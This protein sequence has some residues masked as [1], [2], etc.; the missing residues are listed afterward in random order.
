MV[1]PKFIPMKKN[2]FLFALAIMSS[3]LTGIHAQNSCLPEGITFTSQ[4]QIDSFPANYPGCTVIE[5]NL[6]IQE[7]VVGNIAS[8]DSLYPITAIGGDLWVKDND[9]LT[10][11]NG[12]NNVTSIGMRL[13]VESNDAL[14]NLN[15]LNNLTSIVLYVSITGND[16]L[17]SLNGLDNITSIGGHLI[18]SQNLSLSNLNALK[19]LTHIGGSF[20]LERNDSLENFSGMENLVSIGGIFLLYGNP[21]LINFSGLD[22]L[23]S[24]GGYFGINPFPAVCEDEVYH[25]SLINL[26]GL[27]KLTYIGEGFEI[28]ENPVL[29][30]LNGLDNVDFSTFKFLKVFGNKNLSTCE[31]QPICEYLEN[32]GPA[33]IENNAPGCNTHQEIEDACQAVSVDDMTLGENIQIF[34]NPSN[35]IIHCISPDNRE[36]TVS[37]RDAMGF[38]VI[39]PHQLMNGEID[40]SNVPSGLY[41]LEMNDGHRSITKRIIQQ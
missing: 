25:E 11:L 12:L 24:I 7:N 3:V 27:Q 2:Q 37:V 35:G 22:N 32:G 36:W 13:R 5:G 23:E 26:D 30:N 19:G 1:S 38:M 10:S 6:K 41:F 34:P 4:A 28:R 18:L 21:S 17:A 14:P 9:A 15:G 40:L 39:R 31:I 29:E 8:L 33:T 16:V 20:K